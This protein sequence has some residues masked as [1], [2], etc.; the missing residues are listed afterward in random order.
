MFQQFRKNISLLAT[1]SLVKS[2]GRVDGKPPQQPLGCLSVV[3]APSR[4]G[5]VMLRPISNTPTFILLL[6]SVI[7]SY[8]CFHR[9]P[10]SSPVLPTHSLTHFATSSHVHLHG[11]MLPSVHLSS[12][13]YPRTRA[14]FTF[15]LMG[16]FAGFLPS[17]G[18]S[19]RVGEDPVLH[20]VMEMQ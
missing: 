19:R 18:V 16:S 13:A 15:H 20:E 1:R 3:W 8:L 5:K 11:H 10:T 7:Y 4:G 17:R 9:S 14:S 2:A 12:Q 6:L